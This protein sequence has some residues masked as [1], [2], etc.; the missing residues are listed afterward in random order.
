MLPWRYIGQR[1]TS[2][3]CYIR[4]IYVYVRNKQ[5]YSDV[6]FNAVLTQDWNF[7]LR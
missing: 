5:T 2:A 3:T 4:Y 7:P 6:L 1:S